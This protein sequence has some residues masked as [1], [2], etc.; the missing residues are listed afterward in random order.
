MRHVIIRLIIGTIF[1]V[2]GIPT[3]ITG[4]GIIF[5]LAGFAYIISGTKLLKQNKEKHDENKKW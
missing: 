2:V 4:F 3:V 1:V 5:L